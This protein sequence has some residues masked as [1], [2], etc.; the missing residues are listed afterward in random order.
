MCT[1]GRT[2]EHAQTRNRRHG[3]HLSASGKAT[4]RPP[5][6]LRGLAAPRSQRHAADVTDES[7]LHRRLRGVGV[8]EIREVWEV[9]EV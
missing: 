5:V 3:A 7:A 1:L 8:S 9:R 6:S 4:H 2:A